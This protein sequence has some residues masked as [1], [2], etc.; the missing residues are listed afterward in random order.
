MEM[1]DRK[2]WIAGEGTTI[3]KE[4]RTVD[5]VGLILDGTVR[6]ETEAGNY[7]VGAGEVIG[8]S[9]L[10]EKVYCDT[11]I[12]ETV[13]K[14]CPF[15]VKEEEAL[16]EL[17][18]A[19][20]KTVAI[21]LHSLASQAHKIADLY[22]KVYEESGSIYRTLAGT[23]RKY[24][25]H[26]MRILGQRQHLPE[27]E[28][29]EPLYE[30]YEVDKDTMQYYAELG[31]VSLDE[32][33][34]FAGERHS[35]AKF[36]AENTLDFIKNM[37]TNCNALLD[38]SRE[39]FVRFVSE[40]KDCL[41]LKY[42]R[43]YK[44]GKETGKET[45]FVKLQ[46]DYL[47]QAL[48]GIQERSM[49]ARGEGFGYRLENWR[50]TFE[51]YKGT[52]S[53]EEEVQTEELSE[54]AVRE[55]VKKE[56]R[57]SMKRLLKYCGIAEERQETFT[58]CWNTYLASR[59]KALEE[60]QVRRI[61]RKIEDIFYDI[62]ENV[63]LRAEAENNQ[64]L[65]TRLFLNFGFMDEKIFQEKDLIAMYRCLQKAEEKHQGMYHIYTIRQW[66]QLIFSGEKEPSKNEFDMDYREN[67]LDMKKTRKFTPEEERAYFADQKG[68]LSFEIKNMFR[69]N[70]RLIS[71][72]LGFFCPVL[73]VEQFVQGIEGSFL[74]NYEIEE[75][76]EEIRRVDY[77]AFFR[78][79]M[80]QNVEKKIERAQIMVEV[81]PDLILMPCVGIRGSMWQEIE[82]KR[83]VSPGRFM[84][85]VFLSADISEILLKMVGKFRW[86]LCRTIQGG[87]WNNISER[88]LTSEYCDYLQFYKKNRDLNDQ[89]KQ[90][91]RDKLKQLRKNYCDMF[92]SDYVQWIR[93]ESRGASKLNKVSRDIILR[94]CP[95]S[96]EYRATLRNNPMFSDM[97]TVW[98]RKNE[99]KFRSV[100]SQIMHF[101]KA[102]A[103]IT[104]ELKDTL[105]FYQM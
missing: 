29:L 46:I 53:E 60:D 77:S 31:T 50:K 18:Q 98:E 69:K 48:N 43:L 92:V 27:W 36:L 22:R 88:S 101:E 12:S 1:E 30:E 23:Y 10:Q 68:K 83:R 96:K 78:E 105:D 40:E 51:L 38:I 52:E 91:I 6:V 63:F 49:K 62:Y 54:E 76:M 25:D 72:Q 70:N 17:L 15:R 21:I 97:L 58:D 34:K 61:L 89:V 75:A 3:F 93:Y 73:N 85:P 80:Y 41:A 66:L 104:P 45:G 67:F 94:Y 86:E 2:M 19:D 7:S 103:E 44:T 64:E 81:L 79:T 74:T 16:E 5:F 39:N 28:S 11:C 14:L 65:L 47:L 82:G 56:L 71:G 35:V 55:L 33:Q 32:F 90:K 87:Y 8:F 37:E 59:E 42:F 9:G 26:A 24:Q 102:G 13:V 100:Q 57:D 95:F 20:G 99:L 4:G 84:L